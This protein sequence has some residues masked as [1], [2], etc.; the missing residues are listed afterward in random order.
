MLLS[1]TEL[2]LERV[3]LINHLRDAWASGCSVCL[4]LSDAN[5]GCQATGTEA[6]TSDAETETISI[7]KSLNNQSEGDYFLSLWLLF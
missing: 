4:S 7:N 1:S 5:Q 3:E 6:N 2:F